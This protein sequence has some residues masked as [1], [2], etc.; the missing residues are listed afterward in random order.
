MLV[1]KID[2]KKLKLIHC[3]VTMIQRFIVN[4]DISILLLI[5][6]YLDNN[7]SL[8]CT[9]ICKSM[10]N[11]CKELYY[12]ILKGHTERQ[13]VI[14]SGRFWKIFDIDFQLKDRKRWNFFARQQF[15]SQSNMFFKKKLHNFFL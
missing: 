1:G 4:L 2:L 14:D 9:L 11:R 12:D 15:F 13:M 8:S 3:D 6:D 7:D 10:Q 5:Q